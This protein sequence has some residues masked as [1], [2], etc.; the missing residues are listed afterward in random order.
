MANA[1]ENLPVEDNA[2]VQERAFFCYVLITLRNLA[3][4]PCTVRAAQYGSITQRSNIETR[5]NSDTKH[6]VRGTLI[7]LLV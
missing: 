5:E 3:T 4:Y 2:T 6:R 7:Y 1:K